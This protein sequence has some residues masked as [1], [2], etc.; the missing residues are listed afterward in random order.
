M[1]EE[2]LLPQWGMGMDEGTVLEWLKKVGDE[3]SED[4]PLAEIEAEK[5][6]ETL[7]APAT[8]T[9]TEI[10]VGEG[11]TAKVRTALAIIEVS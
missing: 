4:E 3:V 2:V 8:G 1:K 6:T 5:V 10:L 9:L 7:E 11:E